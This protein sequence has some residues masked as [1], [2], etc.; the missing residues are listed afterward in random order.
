M[1]TALDEFYDVV[2]SPFVREFE[3]TRSDIRRAYGAAW[4]LDSYA[5]HIFYFFR[6]LRQLGTSDIAFKRDALWANSP[7]FKLISDVSAAAKHAV[8]SDPKK[9]SVYSSSDVS[10]I[11]LDGAAAYFA[12]PDADDWGEQVIVNNDQHL[13]RPLLP[14]ALRAEAFLLSVKGDLERGILDK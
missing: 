8:R 11:M 4:A 7:D 12:G 2:V 9:V 3:Q 10:S 13:F 1:R 5:S 6:E 14:S